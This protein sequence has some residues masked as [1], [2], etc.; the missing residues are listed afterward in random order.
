MS[1][2][3]IKLNE[4]ISLLNKQYPPSLAESWDQNGIHFGSSE[5]TVKKILVTLDVRAE[6]VQE[7]IENQ[8]DTIIVHHPPLFKAIQRFDLSQ[9]DV[10]MYA[11]LIKHDINVFAMHTNFDAASN[12]MN[13]WLAE[14]LKL[15]NVSSLVV[16]EDETN[17]G[18]GRVGEFSEALSR[19]DLLKVL[20]ETYQREQLIVIEKESRVAYKKVAIVGGSGTSFINEVSDQEVDLFITGDITYHQGHDLYEAGFMTVDAGHYIESI[21]IPGLSKQLQDTIEKN[22]WDIEVVASQVN[23]NPFKYE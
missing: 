16:H 2:K 8:I 7:A 12:G 21:F 3:Q 13:D 6:V 23:T 14:Q 19:T 5:A 11:Q 17:P 15:E 10:A 18:I 1:K 22:N 9:P 4:L 20:K